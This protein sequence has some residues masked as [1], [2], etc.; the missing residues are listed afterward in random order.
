[1]K[2]DSNK[3]GGRKLAVSLI[4]LVAGVAIDLN[5]ERGLSQNLLYLM[6]F[7]VGAY[8]TA[9]VLVKK[10]NSNAQSGQEAGPSLDKIAE[11]DERQK[12]SEMNLGSVINVV[13]MLQKQVDL[14]NKRMAALLSG[15][16]E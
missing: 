8:S 7:I 11:M 5:T 3:F 6:M 10:T 4:C 15:N 2:V 12:Q 14:A 13:E 9:N 16:K 1:M